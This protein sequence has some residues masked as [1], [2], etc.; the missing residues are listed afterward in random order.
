ML[1]LLTAEKDDLPRQQD[2]VPTAE[3]KLDKER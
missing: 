2:T 3:E 1:S